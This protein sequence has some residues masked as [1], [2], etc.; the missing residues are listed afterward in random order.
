MA[1][2]LGNK[3]SRFLLTL[4]L[5]GSVHNKIASREFMFKTFSGLKGLSAF[6]Y[7]AISGAATTLVVTYTCV[8]F[9]NFVFTSYTYGKMS[10]AVTLRAGPL[11]L[12]DQLEFWGVNLIVA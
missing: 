9:F 2:R 5:K 4:K 1:T 8:A 7:T 3:D 11:V 12:Q 6:K 10:L